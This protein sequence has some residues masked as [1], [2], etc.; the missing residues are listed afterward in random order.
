MMVYKRGHDK[1]LPAGYLA[2]EMRHFFGGYLQHDRAFI[3]V[4]SRQSDP[5]WFDAE[6]SQVIPYYLLRLSDQ[7][8]ISICFYRKAG[9]YDWKQIVFFIITWGFGLR[10]TWLQ[11]LDPGQ[12]PLTIKGMQ[13]VLLKALPKKI[14]H[15]SP[16]TDDISHE[17]DF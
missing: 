10:Y 15:R 17:N 13:L 4:I 9:R 11:W 7:S 3:H 12:S 5:W 6:Y 16:N 1:I 8:R 14:A 2:K